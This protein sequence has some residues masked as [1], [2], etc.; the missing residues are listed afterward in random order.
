MKL[1]PLGIHLVC[2]LLLASLPAKI[3]AD[4]HDDPY[5]KEVRPILEKYCVKCHGDKKVKGHVN[6]VAIGD[7]KQAFKKY[8]L[9][10][11][12]L[13][14]IENGDMPPEDE[15][16]PADEE[17]NVLTD[18]YREMFVAIEPRPADAQLRRLSIAE[19]RNSLRSLLGFDLSVSVS[20]TPE[21]V[22][23]NSLVV[24]MMPSD[25]PGESGFGNDTASSPLTSTH[26]EKYTFLTSSAVENLFS[27]ERRP[28][29]EAYTGS[30]HKRLTR[31][32]VHVLIGKFTKHAFK[33]MNCEDAISQ[34]LS[35]LGTAVESG[36]SLEE[37]AKS[38]LKSALLSPQ[39]LYNGHYDKARSGK[40]PVS[41]AELAQR[42][43]Y[44]LWSTIP[45][46]ELLT[47]AENGELLN[48]PVL[49]R[50]VDR[51]LDDDRSRMFTEIFAREWLDLDEIK[52]SK[53]KWPRVAALYRQPIHFVDYLIREDRPLME[54]IDS[55]VTFSNSHLSRYYHRKDTASAPRQ[56][57]PKGTE[58]LVL[59][60]YKLNIA[61]STDRG[62]VLTMPGIL[63]MY[64]GKNRTSPILR[65]LW[66][67]ERIL[68]DELG[69]PPMD[70]PP[71]PT[72]KK[73][74]KLTFRQIFERHQANKSCATCHSKID[75]LGFGLEDYG[76]AGEFRAGDSIDSAGATPDGDKFDNFGELKTLLLKK[77]HDQIIR[78][79][80]EKLYSFAM[81]R[82]LSAFDR[83]TLDAIAERMI[84]ENGSYRDLI[85][86]I[87]I[88]MPFTHTYVNQERK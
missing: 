31:K 40:Q 82:K 50:Q 19:Y 55:D 23:E 28:H 3:Y 59:A 86:E 14:A 46:D 25:P 81:A 2:L 77:Y 48:R 87:A 66:V 68:G 18:W 43:S 62:G 12:A 16:Q 34:S 45:D 21:T 73:F 83:P 22:Q 58:V 11:K 32:Q 37:A 10:A 84:S 38:E 70:V 60:H 76:P 27:L 39:F 24:K 57:K 72:P 1:Q 51:L 44:F 74:E 7:R 4:N 88:S 13:E 56:A 36:T 75:P 53:S 17:V 78:T 29:L 5:L 54:L 71:I 64:S 61:N 69:E 6:F 79:V 33:T 35:R 41:G 20:G 8:D 63:G 85:K 49:L 52:N 26:W 42:L 9:W 65:G 15:A 80:T 47:L 30:I 67:L